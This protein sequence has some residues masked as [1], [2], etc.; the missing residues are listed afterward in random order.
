MHP[1]Y[2]VVSANAVGVVNKYEKAKRELVY[3][4]GHRWINAFDSLE[5]ATSYALNYLKE[6]A[7]G[8]IIPADLPLNFIVYISELK[9]L[10]KPFEIFEAKEC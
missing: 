3:L 8:K 7:P 9:D 1:Y 4:K 10:I 6:L 2:S 5:D